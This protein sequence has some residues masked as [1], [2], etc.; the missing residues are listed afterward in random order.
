MPKF[1]VASLSSCLTLVPCLTWGTLKKPFFTPREAG[2]E[3]STIFCFKWC[4]LYP[5]FLITASLLQ[6]HLVSKQS[7]K[8]VFSCISALCVQHII[9]NCW[10]TS[11]LQRCPWFSLPFVTILEGS[12]GGR[13]GTSTVQNLWPRG[14]YFASLKWSR[15]ELVALGLWLPAC[16]LHSFQVLQESRCILAFPAIKIFWVKKLWLSPCTKPSTK[17]CAISYGAA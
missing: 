3:D 17:H 15:I 2:R 5:L 11:M 12:H 16:C 4:F 13:C 10:V 7:K 8:M 9:G 14:D 1:Q 6:W